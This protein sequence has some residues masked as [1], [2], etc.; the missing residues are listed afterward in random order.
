MIIAAGQGATAAQS[1][2]R[3][4]FMDSLRRHELP[5]FGSTGLVSSGMG[6]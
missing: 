6:N 1:I 4:L 5:R 2:D 3:E